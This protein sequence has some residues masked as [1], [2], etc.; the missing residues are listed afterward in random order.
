MRYQRKPHD[1]PARSETAFSIYEASSGKKGISKGERGS[2]GEKGLT[3]I[4]ERGRFRYGEGDGN[5]VKTVA[6][7][8]IIRRGPSKRKK[9]H[10]IFKKAA[11]KRNHA[12]VSEVFRREGRKSARSTC[13]I[14]RT[15]KTVRNRKKREPQ[16]VSPSGCHAQVQSVA[17]RSNKRRKTNKKE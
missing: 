5:A 17:Q 15:K 13:C 11:A 1:D 3:D 6:S 12:R 2:M 14:L 9:K 8:E 7:E 4:L 10:K 16:A